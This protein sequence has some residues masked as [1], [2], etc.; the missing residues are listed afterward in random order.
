[1]L[2]HAPFWAPNM[3][4]DTILFSVKFIAKWG[5]KTLSGLENVQEYRYSYIYPFGNRFL[6]FSDQCYP[7][8][9]SA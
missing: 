9:E 2:N 5:R 8:A 3:K 7:K 4:K 1:M 6:Q